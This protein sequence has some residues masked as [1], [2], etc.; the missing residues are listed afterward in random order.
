ME[1][2]EASHLI[3][4]HTNVSSFANLLYAVSIYLTIYSN[5]LTQHLVPDITT[6]V[7]EAGL[8]AK[9]VPDLVLAIGNG[10]TTA[11]ESVPGMNKTILEALALATNQAYA[12]A[13]KIVYLATLGFTAIGFIAAFFIKDVDEYLTTYVNKTIHKP[14]GE[15]KE[16][17]EN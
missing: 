8:P 2:F 4:S 3:S 1:L 17:A 7:E 5:E 11:L 13:F 6:A 10:T 16:V 9:S 12:H 15:K 14:M